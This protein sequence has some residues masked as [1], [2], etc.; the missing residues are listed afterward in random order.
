VQRGELAHLGGQ[1]ERRV[2]VV[3][4]SGRERGVG[5]VMRPRPMRVVRW[6]GYRVGVGRW[7]WRG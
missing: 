3:G 2:V 4:T 7:F 5:V 1:S 6:R